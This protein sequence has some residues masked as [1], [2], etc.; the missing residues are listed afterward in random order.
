MEGRMDERGQTGL[1]KSTQV[2]EIIKKCRTVH[3]IQLEPNV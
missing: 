1:G 3:K 2:K